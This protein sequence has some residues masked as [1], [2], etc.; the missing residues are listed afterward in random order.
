MQEYKIISIIHNHKIWN[1]F[2]FADW[3]INIWHLG[4]V[5]IWNK[6][7]FSFIGGRP[8]GE[9]HRSRLLKEDANCAEIGG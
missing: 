5:R 4:I 9:K 7:K 8:E 3:A 6:L 2:S 1:G